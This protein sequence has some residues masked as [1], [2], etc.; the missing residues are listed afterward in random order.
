MYLYI[1]PYLQQNLQKEIHPGVTPF[2]K[3]MRFRVFPPESI[4][5]CAAFPAEELT[6]QL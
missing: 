4:G 5:V 2:S 3:T 1:V 6:E